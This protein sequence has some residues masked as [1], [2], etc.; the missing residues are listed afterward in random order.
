MLPGH[1]ILITGAAGHDQL[2]TVGRFEIEQDVGL[3]AGLVGTELFFG[4]EG[5]RG[6]GLVF[7]PI[8]L[9]IGEVVEVDLVN[10]RLLVG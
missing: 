10:G 6:A 2:A 5:G 7:C 9:A 8:N 4:F 1:P 3:G